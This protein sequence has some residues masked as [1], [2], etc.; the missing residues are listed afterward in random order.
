[1]AKSKSKQ[2]TGPDL[3]GFFDSIG[4]IAAEKGLTREEI[5]EIFSGSLVTAYQKKYGPDAR[6]EVILDDQKPEIAVLAT[7]KVVEN[8]E[9]PSFEITLKQARVT[10]P[11][12]ET[13]QEIVIR[14][15]PFSSSRIGATN[16]RHIFLQ[17]LKEQE[18]EIIY[19]EFKEKEGELINGY[20]LRWKDRSDIYVD[21]GRAEG[22]LPRREQIPGDRFHSSD[23]VK[24]L[25]KE[26]KLRDERRRDPGPV[27]LLSRASPDFVRRLFE[28]E[29]PEIYE[30]VVE[31][32]GIARD[33]GF[34]TKMLV[35]SNRSDVDPVG[36]CVG[37]KGVRIQ[38]IVRELGK[39]GKERIDI[40]H[41]SDEPAE[42]I[43]NA[44]SPA[45]VAEVRADSGTKE[46]LILV[47]D[48]EYSKAV[49]MS[50]KNV[51]LASQLTGYR[52]TVKSLTQFGEEMSS[53]E[54]RAELEQL[55]SSSSE[56]QE[57]EDELTPLSELPGLSPRVIGLLEAVDIKSVE[58]LI[59]YDQEELEKLD[60]IG[61]AT[62]KQILKILAETVEV[63]EV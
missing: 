6:L 48:N 33:A 54:A 13:G 3:R 4:G 32:L 12:A 16:V 55:F 34:R 44:I 50:G 8:V 52:L 37:I 39:E 18:R 25:I 53:P 28:F 21:L 62:A 59:E 15:E 22:I 26:V 19:N 29:I 58:D 47:P 1:M 7:M 49:G 46:A 42:L 40:V 27:I 61:E 63:E 60:G 57:E 38:S 2:Q 10:N 24:A 43:A 56:E 20:F 23:R 14:E 5:L 17:R 31:I 45:Q 36:A 35:R 30:G 41:Y 51:W 9:D 11:D